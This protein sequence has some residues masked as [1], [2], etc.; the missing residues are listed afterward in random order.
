[1]SVDWPATDIGP[2]LALIDEPGNVISPENTVRLTEEQ[3][4]GILE[5]RL[6]RLTGLERDKIHQDLAK[7]AEEISDLLAILASHP[8]RMDVMRDELAK[9]RAALAT[10]RITDIID[11]LADQ[12]DESLIEPG[13]MVVTITR[14][15]FI[16][17]TTLETFRAQNRG[18]RGRS[19]AST[20]GDDIVTRSFHAHTHQW[21]LFFS[22]GGK[23]FREKVWRLPEAGPTA[24][25]RALVNLLPELGSDTIT[26]VLPLPQD[27]TLW[28]SLHLLFATAS[29]NVRRNRLSDFRNVR[30]AGLIA[31]KLDEGDRLIGVATCRE[32]QDAF[33]ATRNSRC[34]RFELSDDTVRVFAGRDSSG[35]RG[36]R[37]ADGDEVISLSVLR[38]V[39]A[40]NEE[41]EAYVKY[42]NAKRRNNGDDEAETG[43]DGDEAV[44]EV[45]LD[46]ARIKELQEAEEFLLT[47]T[48]AGF[49]KRTSAYEY[50]VTGRGGQGIA[51]ITLAP[52]NGTAVVATLPIE[53]QSD[54][55][56][57]TDAGRLIRVPADQVRITGRQAMGVT[58]FR[59]D[60]GEH[61]TS[62]FPV[63]EDAGD[64]NGASEDE[65]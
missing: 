1:M 28:D 65:A 23:A 8:R 37:L 42:A 63:I 35:V 25:G 41:R 2:L 48:D 54:I 47:V 51:N 19:G 45:Q 17:R 59:V 49:G 24:K 44:A 11:A 34:I 12:E 60:A 64:E 61:V 18:G 40:L 62:V 55:M 3:A 20:R 7:I 43:T 53:D 36:I 57:V 50:R 31:M 21:V 58:L 39:G 29:G 9:A 15:G 38:H 13:Q 16:K 30:S 26:T 6:Q 52:R 10:P 32:G 56:L 33:L 46:E 27:E 4:R 5:I 22:S 14:D